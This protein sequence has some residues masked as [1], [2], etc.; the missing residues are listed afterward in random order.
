MKRN[1][2]NVGLVVIFSLLLFS[3]DKKTTE[4]PTTVAQ[5][6][7]VTTTQSTTTQNST[8]P[9]STITQT[10]TQVTTITTSDELPT[11]LPCFKVTFMVDD[12]VI[13]QESVI[14]G[15]SATPPAD[16]EKAST[17]EYIYS[18]N[19]WDKD[20][21][22]VQNDLVVH[23]IFIETEILYEVTFYDYDAETVIAVVLVPYNAS[24]TPP[25]DIETRTD[26]IYT[27]TFIGWVGD[28]S[29][30]T[31]NT[32]IYSNYTRTYTTTG[33]YEHS[34]FY[35][36]VAS[37]FDLEDETNIEN[38]IAY[39]IEIFETES[40]EEAYQIFNIIVFNYDQLTE[41][42]DFQEFKDIF[43]NLES[44]FL[45]DERLVDIV[46]N[47]FEYSNSYFVGLSDLEFNWY[48]EVILNYT[49]YFDQYN[50]ILDDQNQI[51]YDLNQAILLLDETLRT[52]AYDYFYAKTT[53]YSTEKSK[54]NYFNYLKGYIG[55]SVFDLNT[56]IW[57]ILDEANIDPL[58]YNFYVNQYNSICNTYPLYLDK[59][60]TY[61]DIMT[62]YY[63]ANQAYL[64]LSDIISTNSAYEAFITTSDSLYSSFTQ[65]LNDYFLIKDD[66]DYW[67]LQMNGINAQMEYLDTIREI[68]ANTTHQEL[69]KEAL[70]ILIDDIQ[71]IILTDNEFDFTELSTLVTYIDTHKD[72]YG[73][74][75]TTTLFELI[76]KEGLVNIL[77]GISGLMDIRYSTITSEEWDLLDSALYYLV[78]DY[79][80]TLDVSGIVKEQAILDNYTKASLYVMHI[81][82]LIIELQNF[83]DSITI[84]EI[85]SF[86]TLVI[87]QNIYTQNE[88]T[89]ELAKLIYDIYIDTTFDYTN[90]LTSYMYINFFQ[91]DVNIDYA[92]LEQVT[93]DVINQMG[94]FIA[95]AQWI[96]ITDP[97][98]ISQ[99]TLDEFYDD[100]NTWYHNFLFSYSFYLN[101]D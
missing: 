45:T 73:Y 100:F 99:I 53:F 41:F 19:G 37:T 74:L 95:E 56:A 27:Y 25:A 93:N 42:S 79:T 60:E 86:E 80:D 32:S 62:A 43:A 36:L 85:E 15:S 52:D 16:P 57:N 50:L 5:T 34:D 69:Y 58:L 90:F 9:P 7:L 31:E 77:Q 71:N 3:C 89:I 48:N 76:T 17:L 38:N 33:D 101:Q 65:S 28:F 4:I 92:L 30:I 98:E 70:L 96:S 47:Y 10:T 82:S 68:F 94:S 51:D 88:Y 23:A 67:T 18:F 22:N 1:L 59:I 29:N 14:Q 12:E 44:G 78:E 72:M 11:T 39:L 55:N 24:A 61:R 8:N 84:D 81:D 64:P 83:I 46:F 6:T 49:N 13:K 20:F 54:F 91:V 87:N 2:I 66:L 97:S 75:D 26:E 63:D 21:T 40:E 35:N